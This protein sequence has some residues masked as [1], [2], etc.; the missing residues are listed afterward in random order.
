ML[1][2]N[3]LLYEN[4]VQVT[5]I[6]LDSIGKYEVVVEFDPNSEIWQ[7]FSF[8][9]HKFLHKCEDGF[10][11][12]IIKGELMITSKSNTDKNLSNEDLSKSISNIDITKN[13]L[14]LNLKIF[15]SQSMKVCFKSSN[16]HISPNCKF[17]KFNYNVTKSLIDKE[18]FMDKTKLFT[19]F[20]ALK[21]Q[22]TE[23]KIIY[24][25]TNHE[26]EIESYKLNELYSLYDI[27]KLSENS[28]G[29][30]L[31]LQKLLCLR[32][33]NTITKFSQVSRKKCIYNL[34]YDYISNV[35]ILSC[36][37]SHTEKIIPDINR[38][39]RSL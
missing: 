6:Y 15:F 2:S 19:I 9:P 34:N 20:D 10:L 31:F 22:F 12:I 33:N 11:S 26:N 13:L 23:E 21:F 5:S 32:C 28:K 3:Q 18:S 4:C 1:K 16:I 14:N 39:L 8:N 27:E 38:K 17:I 37:E 25:D 7:I 36:H 35:E 30:E 24:S 29:N